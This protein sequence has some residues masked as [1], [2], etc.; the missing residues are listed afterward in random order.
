[1]RPEP[2]LGERHAVDKLTHGA[3]AFE[4]PSHHEDEHCSLC[5]MFINSLMP[6]CQLVKSPI[7][8]TDY[9]KRYEEKE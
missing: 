8:A 9:C 7:K 2:I 6:R 4:S 5:L 1:M 3:V